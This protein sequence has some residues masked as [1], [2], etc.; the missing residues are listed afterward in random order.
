ME[1]PRD[2]HGFYY[3]WVGRNG[4][5]I[6]LTRDQAETLLIPKKITPQSEEQLIRQLKIYNM[7]QQICGIIQMST[8]LHDPYTDPLLY[9]WY[10]NDLQTVTKWCCTAEYNSD[11]VFHVHA[12]FKTPQRPD[13]LRRSM[14]TTLQRLN[15]SPF[16]MKTFG[17][18]VTIELIKLQKCH[19]AEGMLPYMMKGPIFTLS[20]DDAYLQTL[21][22][23]V[24]HDLHLRFVKP[25]EPNNDPPQMNPMIEEITTVIMA[26]HC[27]SFEDCIRACPEIMAKYLHKPGFPN[28]VNNCLTY[29]KETSSAFNITVYEKY[30]P[31]PECMHQIML[32]QGVQPEIFDKCFYDWITK[33]DSKRNTFV[34][35]GPSNTGKSAF[36]KGLKEILPWGEV[37]N[38]N[39]FAF[40][41]M[42]H[43]T[44]AAW[45]E[46]L[47]SP[48]LCEKAKQIME[49]M[50][51]MIP[52]KFKKPAT[53]ERTPLFITTNHPIWRFCSSEEEALRNRIFLFEWTQPV[54]DTNYYP[55]TSERCCKC[56]YCRASRGGETT[57]S[58]RSPDRMPTSDESIH[59]PEQSIGTDITTT[60]G[61]GSLSST[62]SRIS[63]S[64]STTSSETTQCH[65]N[66][67]GY[68]SSTSSTDD[69]HIDRPGCSYGSS[70]TSNRADSPIPGPS[71]VMEP[72]VHRRHNERNLESFGGTI[73]RKR[74]FTGRG[75][76]TTTPI[77]TNSNIQ[78]MVPKHSSQTQIKTK[79]RSKKSRLDQ[80]LGSKV[81]A[82]KLPLFVPSKENWLGYLSYLSYRYA[83]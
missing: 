56:C 38:S 60:M 75:K 11:G 31:E 19:K 36:I 33:A 80:Q 67:S 24:V 74:T 62:G 59:T 50:T 41:G 12:M 54:K 17:Q 81:G 10:F 68:R 1:S 72:T 39:T 48:E 71:T 26:H 77:P 65:A 20:N 13:A 6:D 69:R 35:Y 44:W 3:L 63:G 2:G 14:L 4:T 18:D 16:F 79:I 32:H 43:G 34:L 7:Q 83:D 49:G 27:K 46:P 78:P 52:V 66:T 64:T 51:C 82:I 70:S 53:L 45:E 23:I 58:S 55:R 8:Q 25:Q 61:S 42:L 73:T 5:G 47:L 22:D 28:I 15:Q 37:C 76:R 30:E 21:S 57:P 40:E 9:A 29:V